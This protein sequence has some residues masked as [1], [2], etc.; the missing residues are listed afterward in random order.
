MKVLR[1]I[2]KGTES[3]DT[4]LSTSA[5]TLNLAPVVGMVHRLP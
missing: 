1:K 3:G 2:K 5:I 4:I